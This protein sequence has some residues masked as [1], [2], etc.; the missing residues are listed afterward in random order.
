MNDGSCNHMTCAVCGCE[1]CWLCMKEISDLHYLRSVRGTRRSGAPKFCSVKLP[2]GAHVA[3]CYICVKILHLR[4]K[5][6]PSQKLSGAFA[7]VEGNSAAFIV[8]G[9]LL[10]VH[11]SVSHEDA[12]YFDERCGHQPLHDAGRGDL[13]A[14]LLFTFHC[15]TAESL[16][17]MNEECQ[18]DLTS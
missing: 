6:A 16:I 17:G 8:Q 18:R 10:D 12:R 11:P 3:M 5:P 7:S 2:V 9:P 4:K 13:E 15:W 14:Q 1:F